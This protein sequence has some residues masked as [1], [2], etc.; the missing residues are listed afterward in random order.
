MM[1][2]PRGALWRSLP[3]ALWWFLLCA[4]GVS[5]EVWKCDAESPFTS[6]GKYEATLKL[7]V[8]RGRVTD[9]AYDGLENLTNGGNPMAVWAC[10]VDTTESGLQGRI[11]WTRKGPQT[12]IVIT[13]DDEF[14]EQSVIR[15]I[16]REKAFDVEFV[17]M[18]GYFRGMSRFPVRVTIRKDDPI[19]TL[20]MPKEK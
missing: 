20:V 16:G 1:V 7:T 12:T 18:T 13:D 2:H 8:D 3:A 14:K 10:G 11:R 9:L 19:C 4:P 5:A 15:V 17:H 6:G